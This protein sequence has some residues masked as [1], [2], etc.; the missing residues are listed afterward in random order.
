[1]M[2]KKN[3]H[4]YPPIEAILKNRKCKKIV[5]NNAKWVLQK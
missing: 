2:L 3:A 1:M 4:Y 5:V